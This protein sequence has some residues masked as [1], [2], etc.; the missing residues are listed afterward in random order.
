MQ[1]LR[2]FCTDVS[3]QSQI[4]GRHMPILVQVKG[5]NE[6][7]MTSTHKSEQNQPNLLETWGNKN[8]IFLC[9][10]FWPT[11]KKSFQKEW[12]LHAPHSKPRC[13]QMMLKILAGSNCGSATVG[14]T[15]ENYRITLTG[16]GKEC[17]RNSDYKSRACHSTNC[18]D[19][20]LQG[21]VM[22]TFIQERKKKWM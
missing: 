11:F 19:Q 10:Q 7:N 1:D 16:S 4:S 21:T 6:I 20:D 3:S 15:A 17:S 13:L 14:A 9:P 22:W 2:H 18:L 12:C 8:I 5:Q